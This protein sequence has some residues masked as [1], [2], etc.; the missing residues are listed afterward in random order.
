MPRSFAAEDRAAVLVVGN[1]ALFRRL[2]PLH[3]PVRKSSLPS[4]LDSVPRYGAYKLPMT[5]NNR[6]NAAIDEAGR[7][8]FPASDPPSWTL[9]AEP[10]TAP[11]RG[12]KPLAVLYR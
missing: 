3:R 10:D 12:R 7:Q 8:S 11:T 9:G 4:S 1:S 6:V 5:Q 2:R